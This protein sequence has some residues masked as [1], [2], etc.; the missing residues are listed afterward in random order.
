MAMNS[1]S[2]YRSS[3]PRRRVTVAYG[4]EIEFIQEPS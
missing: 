4:L 3:T 1:A 2:P